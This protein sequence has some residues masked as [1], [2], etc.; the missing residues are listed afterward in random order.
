[1]ATGIKPQERNSDPEARR[2]RA[3]RHPSAGIADYMAGEA[4]DYVSNLFPFLPQELIGGAIPYVPG[5]ENE[6]V[7]NAASQACSTEKV[8]YVYT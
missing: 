6:A 1:M 2:K 5:T 7:W 8:H 3:S 4:E